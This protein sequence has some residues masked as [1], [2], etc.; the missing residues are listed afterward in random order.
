[1]VFDEV[2]SKISGKQRSPQQFSA[3]DVTEE[4]C[5]PVPFFSV[6]WKFIGIEVCDQ[7]DRHSHWDFELAT[8]T[9]YDFA[10]LRGNKNRL[11]TKSLFRPQKLFHRIFEN[12]HASGN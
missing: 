2:R 7:F 10:F 6:D 11:H 8:I 3:K 12:D 5:H 1:M 4:T 9:S